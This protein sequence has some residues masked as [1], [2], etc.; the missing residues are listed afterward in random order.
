MS[1]TIKIL[2]C[3]IGTIFCFPI[4]LAIADASIQEPIDNLENGIRKEVISAEKI[5]PKVSIVV[6]DLGDN[7]I[8]ARKLSELPVPLTMA[9]LPQTPHS[10]KIANLANQKGH[11]VIMHLPMEAF[12]RPDLLGPGAILADMADEKIYD[13][14][15]TNIKS[16]PHLVGFNNHMGSLLTENTEKM[17][18]LMA[19]AKK[20]DWYFL[21][22]KTSEESVAQNVAMGKGLQTVGR[23]IFL[24]HHTPNTK[25]NLN[26]ILEKQF[27]RALKIASK[28]GSVVIICHPYPETFAFLEN[29]LTSQKDKFHFVKLSELVNT[30]SYRVAQKHQ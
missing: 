13:I 21:D 28:K 9:I 30:F 17:K 12:T 3:V 29:Q 23:D 22:S 4:Y 25:A 26:Q 18:S 20:Q 14:M 2:I 10:K 5:L 6:D 1:S 19:F 24:D 7:S 11:E 15:D 27:S 16:I 8:I